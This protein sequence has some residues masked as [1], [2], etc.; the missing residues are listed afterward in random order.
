MAEVEL[1]LHLRSSLAALL[2]RSSSP[3]EWLDGRRGCASKLR[4]YHT[5]PFALVLAPHQGGLLQAE[6]FL[7]RKHLPFRSV[8]YSEKNLVCP[9]RVVMIMYRHVNLDL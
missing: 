8:R 6:N 2:H 4:V 9:V 3:A 1:E 7:K 5:D